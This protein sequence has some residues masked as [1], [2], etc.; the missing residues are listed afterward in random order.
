MRSALLY[1]VEDLRLV[2]VPTPVAGQENVV[3]QIHACGV[4][5]SDLRKFRT[6]ESG[7]L[8]LPCN[9]GHEF[10]GTVVEVGS[11]VRNFEVGMR[12]MG[13][14]FEGYAEYAL[15]D[16]VSP[17]NPYIPGPIIVPSNVS[18]I[19]AT[20][21][22]PL[23]D[24]I[25]AIEDQACFQ[26]GQTMLIIGGGMMGQLLSIVA[27][28]KGGRVIVSEPDEGRRKRALASGVDAV[29]NP[30]TENVQEAVLSLNDNQLVDATILTIGRSELVQEALETVRQNGTVVLFGSFP[31][32]TK[33]G[34]DFNQIHY[35]ELRLTGSV[36]VGLPPY[37]NPHCFRQAL[38][39]IATG[40][41]PVEQFVN[42]V[43]PLSQIDQAFAAAAQMDTFKII[44]QTSANLHL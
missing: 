24:C 6:I 26:A 11:L 10:V 20:F 13:Y 33:V 18:D 27:K 31:H 41:V 4:C 12:V 16:L 9:L 44:V 43:Y 40:R 5:L 38:E 25:H 32:G 3:I 17:A 30:L 23:A 37:M 1:G 21:A 35:K 28:N 7:R 2:D 34:I 8:K 36:W 29:I 15:L 14:G 42:G 22:E 39:D 19:A